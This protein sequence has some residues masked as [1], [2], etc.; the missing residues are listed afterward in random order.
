MVDKL[1]WLALN[2]VPGVGPITYR[3][4]VARFHAPERVFAASI[5]ELAAVGGIGEKTIC[6]IKEFPAEKMAAEELK[7][8]EDLGGSILTFRDQGYPKNLLEIYDPP[9]LLYVRGELGDVDPLMVAI[10]GSRRGSSYGRAMTRRISKELAS[11]GVTV[12]S[13][14]ARGID[15]FAHLGALEAGGKTIAVFG[16]GIDVI[17]PPENKKLFFDIIGHGAVI[18]EFP[19]STP[20]E[21]KNFPKRNRIIS[22]VSLGVVIVEATADSGSLITA[23]HALEQGREVFAVPGN[24]GMATSKG[25]NRLIKQGAKLVEEAQD[26]L[27]EIIP[28]YGGVVK[29]DDL[30]AL[31]DAEGGILQLLSHT[32][33]H[34]DEI[35]RMSQ[36]EIQRVST[37]LLSL[38]L[39]GVIS[40]LGGKM[41]VRN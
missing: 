35:S 40:Q 39:K 3:N 2:M 12:V 34:I 26:I 36:M 21:G 37:I 13:G 4:L 31:S 38:E 5:Q 19:L 7:K 17:Y 28:Q 24:V 22:G 16:C 18:S 11:A 15:T 8:A 20:P 23:S 32:P 9:P 25:T 1:Y 29:K 27:T 33:L 41:F 6:A 14:M 10:V 30:P